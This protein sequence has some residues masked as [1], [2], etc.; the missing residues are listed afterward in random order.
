MSTILDKRLIEVGYFLSRLGINQPPSQLK[1][2]V[3]NEAYSK[4]YGTFGMGKTNEEFRNSLKNLRDHF[5]GYLDNQRIGWQDKKNNLPQK[6]STA[7]QE[8]F[9]EL[10]KLNDDELWERI[11]PYATI[12][13]DE[14]ISNKKIKT[15]KEY[16]KYFSSEFRG[17]KTISVKESIEITVEHGLIVDKL[18]LF[19]EEYCEEAFIYIAFFIEM[20]YKRKEINN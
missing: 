19:L 4:F 11:R 6:L 10:Q 9:D 5:D 16:A 8:V 2:T 15:V 17:K 7:K 13:Y 20:R 18:K 3:W 1:T 14:K 12:S